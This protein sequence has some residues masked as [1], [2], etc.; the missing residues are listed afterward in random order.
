MSLC[1]NLNFYMPV[2]GDASDY[3]NFKIS[4]LVTN[5]VLYPDRNNNPL[6]AY[7][8]NGNSKIQIGYDQYL[9]FGTSDITFMT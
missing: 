9:N 1:D 3:G 4:T 2:D 7:Y 5:A 8:F 6:G